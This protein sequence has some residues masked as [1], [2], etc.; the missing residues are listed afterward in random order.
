MANANDLPEEVLPLVEKQSL[1][2][3]VGYHF[4][5]MNSVVDLKA[6]LAAQSVGLITGHWASSMP[7][8]S[9]WRKQDRSGGQFIEQTTTSSYR[10]VR[11]EV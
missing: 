8:V 7:D 1:L 4:R 2:T 11:K 5:Y 6:L 10:L 3:S 9:W